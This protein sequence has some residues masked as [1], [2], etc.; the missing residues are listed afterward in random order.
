MVSAARHA[1]CV[2]NLLPKTV[3]PAAQARL[4]H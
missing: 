3:Y 1:A 2:V 4:A